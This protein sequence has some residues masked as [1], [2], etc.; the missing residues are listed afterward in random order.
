MVQTNNSFFI[1]RV[2]APETT[3]SEIDRLQRL[4]HVLSIESGTLAADSPKA[5]SGHKT[6]DAKTN[7]NYFGTGNVSANTMMGQFVRPRVETTCNQFEFDYRQLQGT[8]LKWFRQVHG[9]GRVA[10][11][12]DTDP[13]FERTTAIAYGIFHWHR[14]ERVIHGAL[15]T[16]ARHRLL[17]SFDRS[18]LGLTA[19]EK[20]SDVLAWATDQLTDQGFADRQIVWTR[21]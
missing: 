15:V 13:L 21:H 6:F 2:R 14:K 11:Y 12:I 7:A 16:D 9:F 8:D 17:R 5:N 18:A 4:S 19:T 3:Q 20:S 10:R 1:S